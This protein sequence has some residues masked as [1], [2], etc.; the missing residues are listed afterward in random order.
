MSSSGGAQ[1]CLSSI[2]YDFFYHKDLLTSNLFHNS[3]PFICF[4]PAAKLFCR[5][6][7]LW[8]K[9][10]VLLQP[11]YQLTARPNQ[12]EC[13]LNHVV[14][15]II[16]QYFAPYILL[17]E[18]RKTQLSPAVRMQ[19]R[20]FSPGPRN[21]TALQHSLLPHSLPNH[22]LYKSQSTDRLT[23]QTISNAPLVLKVDPTSR[24]GNPA[25]MLK[26]QH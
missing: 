4:V 1:H 22:T 9:K 2:V 3:P 21:D 25:I 5:T 11:S 13:T 15:S 17:S 20:R 16:D 14:Y 8:I 7:D 6:G 10:L 19:V 23:G 12:F 26:K 18:Q 24:A